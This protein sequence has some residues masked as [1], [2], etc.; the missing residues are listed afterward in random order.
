MEAA[1]A[2]KEKISPVFSLAASAAAPAHMQF[3]TNEPTEAQTRIRGFN[4]ESTALISPSAWL[5]STLQP[6]STPP[7]GESAVAQLVQRYYSSVLG[8]FM[9]ADP[10]RATAS[11]PS[12]PNNPQSWN[13]YSYSQSDPINQND[14]SG[15]D[16]CTFS[17]DFCVDVW[18]SSIPDNSFDQ[19]VANQIAAAIAAADQA[20]EQIAAQLT[21]S[22]QDRLSD[23]ENRIKQDL[24]KSDCA[25][26]FKN[27]NA[28]LKKL[29]QIQTKDLGDPAYISQDGL[30]VANPKSPP[31][32]LYT[33]RGFSSTITINSSINWAL[34]SFQSATL[35]GQPW[36]INLLTAEAYHLGVP[37]VSPDQLLDITILHELS[38]Y[39]G[40]IGDPDKD[41]SVE[42]R[43]WQDCIK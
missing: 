39:N 16:I 29:G 4:S 42:K 34:P 43:L 28:V 15:L 6:A 26:D 13:R 12:N 35:N 7:S 38:H 20:A 18:D 19:D 3:C 41:P 27:L 33:S 5:S 21:M 14:P 9:T 1:Q 25:K 2:T 10:Y 11:S 8:R 37:S 24:S 31:L 30:P 23:A 32:G 17:S 22:L 40:A 36:T